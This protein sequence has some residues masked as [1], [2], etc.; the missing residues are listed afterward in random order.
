MTIERHN[1]DSHAPEYSH[2]VEDYAAQWREYKLNHN[3]PGMWVGFAGILPDCHEAWTRIGIRTPFAQMELGTSRKV[4][5][6]D[7]GSEWRAAAREDAWAHY[8]RCLD[9]AAKVEAAGLNVPCGERLEVVE[10]WPHCLSWW[11]EACDDVEGYIDD[12]TKP[13]PDILVW[14]AEASKRAGRDER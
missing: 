5:L 12:N 4:V 3:P 7:E 14:C 13:V 10:P 9:I 2:R 1:Y 8:D 11:A 6:T